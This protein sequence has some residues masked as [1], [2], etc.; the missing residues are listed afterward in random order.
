MDSSEREILALVARIMQRYICTVTKITNHHILVRE[1]GY[2]VLWIATEH[3]QL[4]LSVKLASPATNR[5]IRF[6]ETAFLH[7]LVAERTSIPM[8]EVVG[9]DTTCQF[10]PWQYLIKTY[11]GGIEWAAVY[12]RLTDAQ[13]T[14]AFRQLGEAV[15]A[16]HT[17]TF[18]TFGD[19]A[20][21]SF[22]SEGI[23]YKT[24]LLNRARRTIGAPALRNVFAQVV[25]DRSDLLASAHTPQLCHD[26]LHHYNILFAEHAGRWQLATILDFDK[27]YA[28]CA[29]SDVARMEFWAHM[30]HPTFWE[31]YHAVHPT[32]EGYEARRPIYQL[33]W[34]LEYA[35][36]SK[37]HL[38][39]TE[40]VCRELGIPAITTFDGT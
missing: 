6:T 21:S 28:G 15:A 29:E 30:H 18:D 19:I 7:R 39:D 23:S 40:R 4:E 38:E 32:L 27:A 3:P 31:A 10:I 9:I 17:I 26:D 35:V 14:D 11:S 2:W 36:M 22:V 37:Q 20:P 25:E 16:L 33:L 8:A 13:R 1:V 12:D 24:V 5:V 34:C